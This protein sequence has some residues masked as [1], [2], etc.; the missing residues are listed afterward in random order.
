MII[1]LRNGEKKVLP[2]TGNIKNLEWKTQT[3]I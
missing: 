2:P 3:K 1:E